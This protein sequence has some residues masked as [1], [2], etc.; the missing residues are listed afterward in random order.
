MHYDLGRE[1]H[2]ISKGIAVHIWRATPRD[3]RLNMSQIPETRKKK[4]IKEFYVVR[5]ILNGA[6]S[7]SLM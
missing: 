7:D 6:F 2:N 1:T 5:D 4:S 3:I